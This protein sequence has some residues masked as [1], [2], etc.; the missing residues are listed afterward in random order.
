MEKFELEATA[1]TP[2]IQFNSQSGE[3][4]I[5]GRAISEPE[6]DF[7]APVLKWFYAYAT[8][9]SDSTR[10]V[11]NLEYF[12]NSASKQFLFFL[13]KLNELFEEGNDVSVVW[14]Y[15]NDDP[16]MKESGFDFSCVV[17]VP[18]EFVGVEFEEAVGV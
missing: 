5:Q 9:P 2:Y 4:I 17:N 10:M 18:F 12:N 1:N 11:F 16:E 13:H 3:M 8:A 7:W 6:E 14:K 15:A